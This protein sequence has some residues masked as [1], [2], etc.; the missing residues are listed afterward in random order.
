[1]RRV[2]IAFA[3]IVLLSV[4]ALGIGWLHDDFIQREMLTGSAAGLSRGPDELYC[5]AGGPR[6]LAG[7]RWEVWWRSPQLTAC[8]FR[9]LSSLTLA[10][11]HR[12]GQPLLAHLHG[13][14]WL[15]LACAGVTALAWSLLGPALA[16]RAG[17]IYGISSYTSSL[18]AWVAARHA[19]VSAAL[20]AWGLWLYVRSRRQERAAMLGLALLCLALL[21]GEGALGGL[22][23]AVAYELLAAR[24]AR[25]VRGLHAAAAAALGVFYVLWYARSGYGTAGAGAYLDPL[26]HTGEFLAALPGRLLCLLGEAVLG[27][28]SALW[29]FSSHQLL[30]SG[31]GALGLILVLAALRQAQ[32]AA[33]PEALRILRFLGLGALLSAI[34]AA[35]ALLGGRVLLVPGIGLSILFAAALPTQGPRSAPAAAVALALGVL[36]LS[37][38]SRLAQIL[39]LRRI[40]AAEQQLG[41]SPL[42]GCEN[43]RHYLLLGTD[44]FSV[45]MYAPYLLA[46]RLGQKSWQQLTLASGDIEVSRP[47]RRTLRLSGSGGHLLSGLLYTINRPPRSPLT[48][49]MQLPIPGSPVDIQVRI[50]SAQPTAVSALRVELPV[51]ADDRGFCWLRY[52]GKQLIPLALPEVGGELRIPHVRGPM[53]F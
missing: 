43:A 11:D 21:G 27:A 36:L 48:A 19:A 6:G 29:S 35:A 33:A 28:P 30:L 10:L 39:T 14:L 12:L 53:A 7:S 38:L 42:A 20:V 9:P 26:H 47:D 24:G 25:R 37:P 34:P 45:A 4:P 5:F 41:R 23:F 2:W 17:L 8:F 22:G 51:A 18:V 52:D 44:E 31:V 49:G 50:E 1:M 13:L 40:A 46:S 32:R 3:V 15:L 16:A